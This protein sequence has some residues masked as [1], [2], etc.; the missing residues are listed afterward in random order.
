[1]MIGWTTLGFAGLSLVGFVIS[2]AMKKKV[3]D[4]TPGT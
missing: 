1:M 4:L 2:L 3:P